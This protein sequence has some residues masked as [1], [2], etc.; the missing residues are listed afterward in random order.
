M[1]K[2][3]DEEAV[4]GCQVKHELCHPDFCS[5]GNKVGENLNMKRDSNLM[6][7]KCL[8]A[9]GNVSYKKVTATENRFTMIGIPLICILIIK[10]GK[11]K[12]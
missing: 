3:G 2:D 7:Q 6:G 1:D 5:V 11:C 12:T 9:A 10:G 8:T 4:F